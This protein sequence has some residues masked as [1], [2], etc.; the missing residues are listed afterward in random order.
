MSE[1]KKEK[2][3]ENLSRCRFKSIYVFSD[4]ETGKNGEFL[5]AASD[6]GN[7]LVVRKINLVYRG[8]IQGLQGSTTIFASIKGNKVLG[9]VVKELDDKTFGI[10]NELRVSSMPEWMGCMLYKC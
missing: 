1:R 4:V 3:V 8:G 10:S 7:A 9:V 5:T 2:E 6:L